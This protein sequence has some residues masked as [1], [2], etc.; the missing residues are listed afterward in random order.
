MNS[1]GYSQI[2]C[3]KLSSILSSLASASSGTNDSNKIMELPTNVST[4][5]LKLSLSKSIFVKFK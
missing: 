3:L 5:V 2:H 1:K 4:I